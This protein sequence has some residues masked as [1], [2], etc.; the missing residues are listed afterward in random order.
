MDR[1]VPEELA[2]CCGVNLAVAAVGVGFVP[3]AVKPFAN[4]HRV[5]RASSDR[6]G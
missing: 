5:G 2:S 6:Q 3:Q 1:R 4:P